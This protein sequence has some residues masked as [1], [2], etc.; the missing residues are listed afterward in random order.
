MG[1]H[2]TLT[3]LRT[4]WQHSNIPRNWVSHPH[5]YRLSDNLLNIEHPT[6]N[7]DLDDHTL[8]AS[9]SACCCLLVVAFCRSSTE[10]EAA[11]PRGIVELG[12][13]LEELFTTRAYSYK[14]VMCR[15]TGLLCVSVEAVFWGIIRVFNVPLHCF[16]STRPVPV[17][18][19]KCR[20]CTSPS[21]YRAGDTLVL[22]DWFAKTL[23]ITSKFASQQYIFIICLDTAFVASCGDVAI[24][25]LWPLIGHL[26]TILASDWLIDLDPPDSSSR[27]Q[28]HYAL[29]YLRCW[30]WEMWF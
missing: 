29:K 18:C 21:L 27:C 13:N 25:H 6:V 3:G 24:F 20:N 12:I 17:M 8:N 16:S 22:G 5:F 26:A 28:T 9:L 10:A 23:T 1:A 2:L 15:V 14:C 19:K 7:L 11:P 30:D 4:A